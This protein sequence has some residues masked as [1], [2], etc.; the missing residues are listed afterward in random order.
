M[1]LMMGFLL[2]LKIFVQYLYPC[3]KLSS[4]KFFRRKNSCSV[5]V[6]VPAGRE[7]KL[8]LVIII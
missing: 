1:S 5:D 8:Q 2:I 7:G 6:T 3:R 4:N